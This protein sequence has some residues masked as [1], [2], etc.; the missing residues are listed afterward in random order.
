MMGSQTIQ[1]RGRNYSERV[2]WSLDEI[3]HVVDFWQPV[4]V[5]MG[6]NIGWEVC[7]E[8][9]GLAVGDYRIAEET[10]TWP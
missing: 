4:E 1:L 9:G 7:G 3:G 2:E 6:L 5:S 10:V 8:F